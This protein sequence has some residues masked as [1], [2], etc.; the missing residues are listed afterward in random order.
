MK[1]VSNKREKWWY[2]RLLKWKED[3]VQFH[4][5]SSL[6]ADLNILTDFCLI[7][8]SRLQMRLGAEL[9]SD[10]LGTATNVYADVIGQML[11]TRTVPQ[12]LSKSPL[13]WSVKSH[14]LYPARAP[15]HSQPAGRLS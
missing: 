10:S 3:Q 2:E 1:R 6:G 12:L 14:D 5:P 15:P 9:S 7:H 11:V 8:L 13:H 4:L